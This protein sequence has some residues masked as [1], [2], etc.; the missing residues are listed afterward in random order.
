MVTRRRRKDA[1]GK[2][3][4]GQPASFTGPVRRQHQ[5]TTDSAV[6][7]THHRNIERGNAVKV[8]RL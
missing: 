8:F 1:L 4:S 6:R 2:A 5:N 3:D 7:V